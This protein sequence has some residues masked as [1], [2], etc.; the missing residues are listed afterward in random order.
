MTE[1]IVVSYTK[2]WSFDNGY[3]R[4]QEMEAQRS[5]AIGYYSCFH[6]C[7]ESRKNKIPVPY[8][9]TRPQNP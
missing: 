1:A 2:N 3:E 5:S 4:V 9:K 8:Y 7:T 6:K